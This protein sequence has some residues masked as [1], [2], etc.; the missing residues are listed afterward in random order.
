MAH[1]DTAVAATAP[2]R[3][4]LPDERKAITHK[5][6]V[7][8]HEGYVT[9]GLYEDGTPGEIFLVLAKEGS[10]ISGLADAFAQAVSYC[11]QYGVPLE[12]L[13][14]KFSHVRFEP[15]GM[16]KNPDLRFAESIVDYVFRWMANRFPPPQRELP[17]I[18]LVPKESVFPEMGDAG[19][20]EDA[21]PCKTCGAFMVRSGTGYKCANCGSCTG[22]AG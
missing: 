4:K 3:R 14:Y 22:F 18:R 8:G 7:A 10:T 17:G 15:A 21:P 5:F 20:Q 19:G 16:T 13:V 12:I 1:I 9:V 6:D 2:V 11:L